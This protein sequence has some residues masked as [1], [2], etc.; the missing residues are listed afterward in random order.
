MSYFKPFSKVYYEFPDNIIRAY[1]DISIRPAVVDALKNGE[2]DLE[3]YEIT[4]GQT[5]ETIAFDV[6]GRA[7]LHWTIMLANDIMNLYTDW[8]ISEDEL[9]LVLSDKYRVQ[10]D[11]EGT[12]VTLDDTQVLEFLQFV[13][14]PQNDYMSNI[15]VGSK[16][17]VIHPHHFEDVDG[18]Y[19]S[20]GSHVNSKDA[21]GREV[22]MPELFPVSY[23]EYE[24]KL[25]DAKRL[26]NLPSIQ[27]VQRMEKEL[28]KLVNE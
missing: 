9:I 11:S 8:P 21:F 13:G 3:L 14:T 16:T 28:R 10:Y 23:Y 26:I 22:I 17:I 2:V 20:W 15:E 19:Y 18:N 27:T 1:T 4:D 6:Y 12:D 5:P 25:N 24:T 7:N